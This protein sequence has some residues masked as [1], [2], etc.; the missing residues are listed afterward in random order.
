MTQ[1]CCTPKGQIKRYVNCIGCDRKP[2]EEINEIR[3][4]KL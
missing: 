3:K 4:N 1:Q 2:I